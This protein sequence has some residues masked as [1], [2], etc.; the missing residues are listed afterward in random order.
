ME[1]V[2]AIY[3]DVIKGFEI[4]PL[5]I[6][7]Y[8]ILFALA[9]VVS[10]QI[11][12]T[13]YKREGRSQKELDFLAIIMVIGTVVGAR[14]GHCLFYDPVYYLSNPIE[15][16]MIRKG[17]LASHGAAIGNLIGLW[18]FVKRTKGMTFS[19]VLDRLATVIP[20]A[21]SFVRIGN[22]FNSEI[23]GHP[24]D[25]PWAVIFA[26]VD[27]IPRHPVQLYEAFSYIFISLLLFFLYFKKDAGKKP[28][29]LFGLFLT[30]LFGARFVLEYFKMNQA[31]FA[32]GW[33]I[34]MGQILSI[35]FVALGLFLF[36][37]AINK[38]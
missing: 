16:L 27:Q 13:I 36:F 26:Q 33:S 17:G 32:V 12:F 22:F 30:L 25:A 20:L 5:A 19:W 24:S 18:I 35:P 31:A 28:G 23:I 29:L 15:I 9:F 8:G 7:W 11:M 10:Y 3:W 37:K 14:L 34:N 4:G 1:I 21:G 2:S 6:R 38:K